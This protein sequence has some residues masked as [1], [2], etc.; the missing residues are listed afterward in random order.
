MKKSLNW[1]YLVQI[2]F[3]A[4]SFIYW[5][6]GRGW[7]LSG[8][9]FYSVFPLLGLF[10]FTMMWFHLMVAYLKKTRPKMFD[11]KTFYTI[12]SRIVLALIILH[13]GLLIYKSLSQDTSF[14]D[15]S[16][17]NNKI[18]IIFGLIALIVFLAYEVVD[19]F[20]NSSIIVNNQQYVR[21]FNRAAFILVYVHGLQVGQHLQSG[22]LKLLWVFYG[23]TT[24]IYLFWAYKTEIL[25]DKE[26]LS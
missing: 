14:L 9:S 10:A 23:L 1:L 18:F 7:S 8:L 11:Y 22:W 2:V 16:G 26:I 12:T 15:Y 17:S 4:P 6:D 5:L 20:K 21:A 25:D 19:K 24:L 13:P 3:L